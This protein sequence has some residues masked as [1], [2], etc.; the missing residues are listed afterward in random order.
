[1]ILVGSA[2]ERRSPVDVHVARRLREARAG[3][4]VR[5]AELAERI[6]VTQAA[7]L[8]GVGARRVSLAE[9]DALARAL[10][11]PLTYFLDWPSPGE[12]EAS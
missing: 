4:G 5:Q 7:Q 2:L 6:G 11:K 1:V 12:T 9:L 10:G 3:L 8:L